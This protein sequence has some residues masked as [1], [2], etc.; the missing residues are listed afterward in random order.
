DVFLGSDAL[1]STYDS[2]E[3]VMDNPQPETAHQLPPVVELTMVA[4]DEASYARR[5]GNGTAIPPDIVP[6]TDFRDPSPDQYEED[7]KDLKTTLQDLRLDYRIFT[8]R[9]GLRA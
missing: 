3:A 4:V 6:A 5:Y 1:K 9:V 2:T 8:T 7:L